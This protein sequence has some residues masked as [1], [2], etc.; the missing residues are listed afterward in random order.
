[1]GTIGCL[2]HAL[3][4]TILSIVSIHF[5]RS[6]RQTV[7]KWRRG[8][9]RGGLNIVGKLPT[10]TGEVARSTRS[11]TDGDDLA[12]FDYLARVLQN[13]SIRSKPFSM[14]AMLVA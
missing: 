7:K 12:G 2:C 4:L 14:F 3:N 13:L 11:R 5:L 8:A 10:M 6:G 1:M 9:Q